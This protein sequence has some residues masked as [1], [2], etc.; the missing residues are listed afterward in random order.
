VLPTNNHAEQTLRRMVIFRKIS[1]GTR[2]ESGLKTHSVLPSL[3]LTAKRQGVDP[4]NF[5]KIL[6]TSDT[7]SAQAALYANSS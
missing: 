4:K 1:F 6:L 7:V 5:L 3:V 2:S